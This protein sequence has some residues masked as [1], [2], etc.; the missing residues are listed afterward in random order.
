M[1]NDT[2][3]YFLESNKL[4][5]SLRNGYLL[6][7]EDDPSLREVLA[8]LAGCMGHEARTVGTSQEAITL[9]NN[10]YSHIRCAIVDLHLDHGPSTDNGDAVIET[11]ESHHSEI[12]Y[13]VYTGDEQAAQEVRKK[14]RRAVVILKNG[15][16]RAITKALAEEPSVA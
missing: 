11:I 4:R 13:L 12:P 5:Q 15:D 8:T 10:D 7:V 9:I 3:K 14:H 16:L 1:C 2:E 6:F